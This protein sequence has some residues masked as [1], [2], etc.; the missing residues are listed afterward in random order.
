VAIDE[1]LELLERSI[2][3]LQ[4]EW[5]KFF[6][7]IE[8]RPPTDMKA[9]VER[10]TRKYEMGEIRNN[11]SR[12]RYQTLIARY[13]TFN[14]LWQKRLRALE[15][16]RPLGVHGLRAQA[17]PP[18]GPEPASA[19]DPVQEISDDGSPLADLLEAPS[20]S[21]PRPAPP[22]ARVAAPRAAEGGMRVVDPSR[23]K[24]AVQALYRQFLE[25][26]KR[27]GESA[28]VKFD[29][30]EKLISQQASRILSEKGATAVDFRLE[31]KDGKVSLKAR[32]VK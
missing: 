26:R 9:R 21:A 15:E 28:N 23:D 16:G 29:S 24:D 13:A 4:I 31:T 32:P 10:M 30:F 8:K 27:T 1:D 22:A 6:Q 5:E 7:G 2:R 3:L 19:T 14:E 12:F 20:A 18:P 11:T 25:E 17:L